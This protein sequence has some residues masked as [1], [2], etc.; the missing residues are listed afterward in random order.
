M[1]TEVYWVYAGIVTILGF[2]LLRRTYRHLKGAE[3]ARQQRL[4]EVNKFDAVRTE[5]PL[6]HPQDQARGRARGS[7]EMR[8]SLIRATLLPTLLFVLVL[9]LCIPLLGTISAAAFT[10]LA[11]VV[12]VVGG[13]AAKP[14][15]ENFITG[16]L[17]S[18]AKPIRIGDTVLIDGLFGTIEDITITHTM[19][20]V[21]DWRRLMIPNQCMISKEFVNY[22]IV[23][24]YQWA[25][26]EFWVSADADLAIVGDMAV[27]AAKA[28]C[29]FA[30]YE[31]PQFWVMELGKEA[32]QCWIAAWADTPS[33]AWQLTHDI[34][35]QLARDLRAAGIKT[36]MHQ[37]E[38]GA[39]VPPAAELPSR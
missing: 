30:G 31:E 16:M 32:I 38:F 6:D 17:I 37:H 13:I 29:R 5:S 25:H 18:F 28:S 24:R 8:F 36:H 3:A 23:D 7:V 35:T 20:K 9:L 21:W 26:V 14:A 12:G 4:E 39:A 11:A 19:I 22:S 27:E 1:P 34:R 15:L 10:L 33:A 2:L